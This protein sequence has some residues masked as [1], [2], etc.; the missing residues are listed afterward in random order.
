MAPSAGGSKRAFTLVELLVAIVIIG[1]LTGLLLPALGSA[2]GL[3]R[4]A[5]CQ[6]NL[7]Q[8]G[9]AIHDY[10]GHNKG[11]IP[12]G[13]KAGPVLTTTNFYPSTGA[14]T[15]LISL[16]NGQPVG[17]GLM[18]KYE[19]AQDPGVLF[20]P[21]S[22]Q[23]M[24]AD[25]ELAKVGTA[26]AQCSYYYRHASVD[27]LYDTSSDVLSPDHIDLGN[28]GLNRNGK[29]IRA[30]VM[31]TQ[32]PVGPGFAEFGIVPRT[33]HEGKNVNVL[34][35]DGHVESLDNSDGRFTVN[36]DN[37]KALTHP[38]SVIL[39]VMEKADEGP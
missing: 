5:S 6:N 11:N 29:P 3:A 30:L 15:S 21:G 8:I 36:L 7:H 17:L 12:F 32:F 1:L 19:L 27:R 10:A 33:H 25:V 9:V 24:N 34:Y 38:F 31:D 26:Q 28:L 13:P 39:S 14:P 37:F 18:L 22:D 16:M 20:C 4:N 35:S 2:M 23:P